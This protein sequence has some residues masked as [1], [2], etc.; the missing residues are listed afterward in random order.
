MLLVGQGR[1]HD[2]CCRGGPVRHSRAESGGSILNQSGRESDGPEVAPRSK[3]YYG[4]RLQGIPRRRTLTYGQEG[5]PAGRDPRKTTTARTSRNSGTLPRPRGG[6]CV[7]TCTA[8]PDT[9]MLWIPRWPC[10]GAVSA[11]RPPEQLRFASATKMLQQ[12]AWRPAPHPWT[13]P[14]RFCL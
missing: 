3:R 8:Q 6:T 5:K 2:F 12:H 11:P 13:N 4:S 10:T 7:N 1:L 14:T 9:T